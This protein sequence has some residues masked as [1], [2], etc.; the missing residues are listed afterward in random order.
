MKKINLYK[1]GGKG[2]EGIPKSIQEVADELEERLKN[3][4]IKPDSYFLSDPYK[5]LRKNAFPG[6]RKISGTLSVGNGEVRAFISLSSEEGEES[7][8]KGRMCIAQYK[9]EKGKMS[10]AFEKATKALKV[11]LGSFYMDMEE[12]LNIQTNLENEQQAQKASE[13]QKAAEPGKENAVISTDNRSPQEIA[14]SIQQALSD[15]EVAEEY[16]KLQEQ[17]ADKKSS[18]QA[19]NIETAKT[20]TIKIQADN[21]VLADKKI[22]EYSNK[23]AGSESAQTAQTAGTS[24]T[25]NTANTSGTENSDLKNQLIN[26]NFTPAQ[27]EVVINLL[28]ENQNRYE[29]KSSMFRLLGDVLGKML[30]AL[31]KKLDSIIDSEKIVSDKLELIYSA[32]NNENYELFAERYAGLEQKIKYCHDILSEAAQGKS[33]QSTSIINHILNKEKVPVSIRT[34]QNA[35]VTAIDNNVESALAIYKYSDANLHGEAQFN[36]I[37]GFLSHALNTLPDNEAEK[38]IQISSIKA[39]DDT[40]IFKEMLRAGKYDLFNS[41]LQQCKNIDEHAPSLYYFAA[42]RKDADALHTL[43]SMNANINENGGEALYTCFETN[44]PETAKILINFGADIKTLTDRIELIQKSN[45][46]Y[47]LPDESKGF[48]NEICRH[49]GFDGYSATLQQNSTEEY[50]EDEV[51]GENGDLGANY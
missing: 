21:K 4:G 28:E 50:A 6:E 33:I 2:E 14:K 43:A 31:N 48:L 9:I 5:V 16:K 19:A 39:F 11:M 15:S 41:C 20:Q 26:V 46:E 40:V 49:A 17:E 29:P 13:Q 27:A 3:Q 36:T 10:E 8:I 44:K 38:F 1:P 23:K 7:Q 22:V 30:H 47:E 45:P 37:R 34:L 32:I 51:H 24:E 12:N 25:V 42:Q 35:F 18:T